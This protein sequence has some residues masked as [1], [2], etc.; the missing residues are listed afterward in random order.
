MKTPPAPAW[1]PAYPAAVQLHFTKHR[2]LELS[3]NSL[4]LAFNRESGISSVAFCFG[5]ISPGT[6]QNWDAPGKKSAKISP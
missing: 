2:R 3:S 1:I 6:A 4:A 5:E